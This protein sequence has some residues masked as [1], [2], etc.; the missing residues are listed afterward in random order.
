MTLTNLIHSH[1]SLFTWMMLS[2][3]SL[4]AGISDDFD[5]LD[6]PAKVPLGPANE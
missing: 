5:Y 3:L 1:V 2:V 4:Q 6:L